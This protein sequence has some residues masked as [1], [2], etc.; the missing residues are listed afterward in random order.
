MSASLRRPTP[1]RATYT[2]PQA[3]EILGMPLR[4]LYAYAA[5]GLVPSVHIGTRKVVILNETVDELL[6]SGRFRSEPIPPD[7]W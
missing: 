7:A 6:A 1:A 5:R 3:A 2:V 4:T